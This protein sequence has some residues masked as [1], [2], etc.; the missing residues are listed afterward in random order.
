MPSLLAGLCAL[1]L[2]S[3]LAAAEG[4][5]GPLPPGPG[6]EKKVDAARLRGW[7]EQLGHPEFKVRARAQEQ[8]R[9]VGRAALPALRAAATTADSLEVRLRARETIDAIERAHWGRISA[10]GRAATALLIVPP[11]ADPLGRSLPTP[12]GPLTAVCVHPSGLFV[13]AAGNLGPVTAIPIPLIL[14]PGKKSEKRLTARVVRD[15]RSLGLALLQAEEKGPFPALPLEGGEGVSELAEVM[16]LAF[17]N[18]ASWTAGKYPAPGAPRGVVT[19]VQMRAGEPYRIRFELEEA[20]NELVGP[21][22]DAEG[23]LAGV[24]TDDSSALD[25][26]GRA[27]DPEEGPTTRAYSVV[28]A[29]LVRRFLEPPILN[30]SPPVV[31]FA[32]R[33]KPATFRVE[34]VPTFPFSVPDTLE[35]VLPGEKP[36]KVK[37]IAEGGAYVARAVP[38]AVP[39]GGLPL[40]IIVVFEEGRLEARI[41]DRVIE[42]GGV[43]VR[44]SAIRSLT[45]EPKQVEATL[46]DG[47]KIT[48]PPSALEG[49]TVRI[50]GE[51]RPIP[52]ARAIQTTIH[53]PEPTPAVPCMVVASRA[54]KELARAAGSVVILQPEKRYALSF[55]GGSRN[56][57]IIPSFTLDAGRPFTVEALLTPSQ[58]RF[59]ALLGSSG[60]TGIALELLGG[61]DPRWALAGYH[62]GTSMKVA[63]K[64]PAKLKRRT[65]VAG[66]FDGSSLTLYVDGKRQGRIDLPPGNVFAGPL[67]TFAIEAASV[68]DGRGVRSFTGLLEGVRISRGTRYVKDFTPP[69]AFDPDKDS[70][71]VLRMN[72][73][74][75]NVCYDGS[76]QHHHAIVNGARWVEVPPGGF[77]PDTLPTYPTRSGRSGP[78]RFPDP[79]GRYGDRGFRPSSGRRTPRPR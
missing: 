54:G 63:S 39:P 22:L 74:T 42:A 56:E 50:G 77:T 5:K 65:H 72:E 66:V 70:T 78:T 33:N 67:R 28:P 3:P 10:A 18:P 23:H 37:M 43:K 40:R 61:D 71:L 19:A 6:R 12:T 30:F 57:L 17:P 9:A 73:G 79:S 64:I 34:V 58:Y 26:F 25:R 52:F 1:A 68:P 14:H 41:E 21:V 47:K 55:D 69:T 24:V 15:D 59:Q 53:P 29:G 2:I 7:I 35:L 76:G 51:S 45:H 32:E 46:S 20:T 13:T 16:A 49:L 38:L 8:L 75:G 27:A 36:R 44:L 4:A 48:L 60:G 31:S 62:G 11:V